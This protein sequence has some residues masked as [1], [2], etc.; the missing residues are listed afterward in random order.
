MLFRREV[1]GLASSDWD[2]NGMVRDEYLSRFLPVAMRFVPRSPGL[3]GFSQDISRHFLSLNNIA[4]VLA[5]AQILERAG[6][7]EIV[8]ARTVLRAMYEVGEVV[9]Y[10]ES[11]V[12]AQ[13]QGLA[14][15]FPGVSFVVDRIFVRSM[16]RLN[17]P[18]VR[19]GPLSAG[20]WPCYVRC[21]LFDGTGYC[22][23]YILTDYLISTSARVVLSKISFK[24][25]QI[26]SLFDSCECTDGMSVAELISLQRR[27]VS[28]RRMS[29]SQYGSMLALVPI[30]ESASPGDL[31]GGVRLRFSDLSAQ[32]RPELTGTGVLGPLSARSDLHPLCATEDLC[33]DCVSMTSV[34]GHQGGTY[35]C[36]L[37]SAERRVA[38]IINTCPSGTVGG[39]SL[40]LLSAQ[41]GCFPSPHGNESCVGPLLYGPATSPGLRHSAPRTHG[42]VYGAD[43]DHGRY[44]GSWCARW[45]GYLD[46]Q[47]RRDVGSIYYYQTASIMR[48]LSRFRFELRCWRGAVK[49][50][51][52]S[53]HDRRVLYSSSTALLRKVARLSTIS[54]L[55]IAASPR[56]AAAN[57]FAPGLP[58]VDP[59]F[60]YTG[61]CPTGN[62]GAVGEPVGPEP[63]PARGVEAP[64]DRAGPVRVPRINFGRVIRVDEIE[65]FRRDIMIGVQSYIS[66]L[67]VSPMHGSCPLCLLETMLGCPISRLEV[68]RRERAVPGTFAYMIMSLGD[69]GAE[70]AEAAAHNHNMH[71]YNGNMDACAP[72]DVVN[73]P[74]LCTPTWPCPFPLASQDAPSLISASLA[75]VTLVRLIAIS[76]RRG[77][78]ILVARGAHHWPIEHVSVPP[79]VA[80]HYLVAESESLFQLPFLDSPFTNLRYPTGAPVFATTY[81]GAAWI[82]PAPPTSSDVFISCTLPPTTESFKSYL[83]GMGLEV[84]DLPLANSTGTIPA[85][86]AP[87][88]IVSYRYDLNMFAKVLRFAPSARRRL[89]AAF[90]ESDFAP[91]L[92]TSMA[93]RVARRLVD[94]YEIGIR[95]G[96][97]GMFIFHS[98]FHMSRPSHHF[99]S[100][101]YWVLD[102][103]ALCVGTGD[104]ED[105]GM[106]AVEFHSLLGVTAR[107]FSTIYDN[108]GVFVTV[109]ALRRIATNLVQDT[110]LLAH[111]GL[112]DAD[113]VSFF[114]FSFDSTFAM[115][116]FNLAD[117]ITSVASASSR[118]TAV[119][120]YDITYSPPLPSDTSPTGPGPKYAGRVRRSSSDPAPPGPTSEDSFSDGLIHSYLSGYGG[121][122]IRP[123]ISADA[124]GDALLFPESSY[125]STDA[126]RTVAEYNK[127]FSP[128]T[129]RSRSANIDRILTPPGSVATFVDACRASSSSSYVSA[130]R[131]II[132]ELLHPISPWTDVAT[133]VGS[134]ERDVGDLTLSRLSY[135]DFLQRYATLIAGV[136]PR[137]YTT[138]ISPSMHLATIPYLGGLSA[139]I[140]GVPVSYVDYR[141]QSRECVRR[142]YRGRG[143]RIPILIVLPKTVTVSSVLDVLPINARVAEHFITWLRY[144]PL[145]LTHDAGFLRHAKIGIYFYSAAEL[146]EFEDDDDETSARLNRAHIFGL[147]RDAL[148]PSLNDLSVPTAVASVCGCI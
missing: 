39:A 15:T 59:F 94:A 22:T 74:V 57:C 43:F 23:F 127:I 73:P 134:E 136:G 13:F 49:K 58:P 35:D 67:L 77:R 10:R 131:S 33:W 118:E 95:T 120:E 113:D 8:P 50:S 68:P 9:G 106:S 30:D 80:P 48:A 115:P 143:R 19:D 72:Y 148:C 53:R 12:Y 86:K 125:L 89:S 42:P 147:W 29:I 121:I 93:W 81:L 103:G 21:R 129:Y 17:E 98:S 14:R 52:L 45:G 24:C 96:A 114:S 83:A 140:D 41:F 111:F 32:R 142:M 37:R 123:L 104:L 146:A 85:M 28:G 126:A 36:F 69:F 135:S 75:L 100:V 71:A 133:I 79:E 112:R 51:P 6:P 60:S 26:E 44:L 110:A 141:K 102:D 63:E 132:A 78:S 5:D 117:N 11:D 124:A 138:L 46:R 137:A 31:M 3:D 107:A 25:S 105:A 61:V 7:V 54:I 47:L 92:N 84:E 88:R 90:R 64:A 2:G 97:P 139:P 66:S 91:R 130:R 76:N 70:C 65:S 87:P 16:P 109:P 99:G 62:A 18:V 4:L 1:A 108:V 116:L 145:V 144:S 40:E 82:L 56:C 38:S 55:A 27:S 20:A 122:R 128:Q 34:F 101:G 119:E